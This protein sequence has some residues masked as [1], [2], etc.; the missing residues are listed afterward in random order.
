[1]TSSLTTNLRRE[2]ELPEDD[3]EALEARGLEWETVILTEGGRRTPWILIREYRI[4]PGYVARDMPA[5][6]AIATVTAGVR[7]VGYPGGALDMIYVH[8]PLRR[9]DGR[10]IRNLS[11][12]QLDGRTFQQWSRH[13]TNANPFRVGLDTLVS[14]LSLADEWFTREF[15]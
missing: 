13:Y 11:D 12:V 3:V 9:A 8:P 1:V 2:F 7:L 15:R 10:P 14:H 5:A 6:D 4:P